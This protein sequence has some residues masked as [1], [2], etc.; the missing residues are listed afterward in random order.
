MTLRHAYALTLD[1]LQARL[2][3]RAGVVRAL[4]DRAAALTAAYERRV[5]DLWRYARRVD[6]KVLCPYCHEPAPRLDVEQ[7][8]TYCFSCSYWGHHPSTAPASEEGDEDT[9]AEHQGEGAET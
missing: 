6:D 4:Q 2:R 9:Q 1:Q 3:A 5:A 8:R 7:L